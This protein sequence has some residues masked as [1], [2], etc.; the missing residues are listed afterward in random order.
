MA[1]AGRIF[2]ALVVAGAGAGGWYWYQQRLDAQA[3]VQQARPAGLPPIPVTTELVQ[4][5]PLPIEIMAN[6][7]VVPEAVVTVR[8]RVDGQVEQ[9]LVE[10]GQMVERGDPLFTLDSRMNQA[11]LAQQEA[12]LARDRALLSRA[13]SDLVRY[14]SLR[15]EGYAAQ[16]RFE[17]A[18]ADAASAA[19]I[20]RAD[21]A[22]VSQTRLQIEFASIRA[23]MSGRLGALP[24]RPGNFV[25]QAEN[26]GMATITRMDPIL[27]QFS[28]P[29]RW[30]GEIRAAMAAGGEGPVVRAFPAES[31]DAPVEGRLVFVDSAVDTQTGTIALK[32]RFANA[33]VRLWPG[34]YIRVALIPRIEPDALSVPAA[35]LQVG[36]DGRFVFLLQGNQAK[37]RPVELV[38]MTAGRAVIRGDFA[39]T[40][41]VIVEGAQRVADGGRAVERSAPAQGSQ[42]ISQATR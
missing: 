27:V 15:G 34:Q 42:R 6:G 1:R 33:P 16:Q 20:V 30:L 10:E 41:R 8:P 5:G 26:V 22:I 13:Q 3:P 23:E 29:E 7:L 24:L 11:L 2:L 32:A 39:A 4:R 36:Q 37:R 19:A 17:Q 12:Q 35:A 25:R 28:V 14:Q 31:P 40:D 18:Q 9:V 38:R 21:E